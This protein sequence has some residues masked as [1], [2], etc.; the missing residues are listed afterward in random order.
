MK[1]LAALAAMIAL[2]LTV[3]AA[4]KDT[5]TKTSKS[6]AAAVSFSKDVMPVLSK[7]CMNC[8]SSDDENSNKFYM[9]NYE[10][11][12]KESKHGVNIV[13]GKGEA[14]TLVKKMRGTADF[15]ARMPKRGKL[16]PD[17]T[18]DMISHW[19]DQGAK[20]N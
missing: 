18:I 14:S 16:V 13:P 3:T 8:H 2:V 11:L 4:Q 7:K 6:A 5:A 20:K 9:D 10:I 19:I 12:M 1:F 15:G 17:S